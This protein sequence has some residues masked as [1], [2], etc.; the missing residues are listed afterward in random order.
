MALPRVYLDVSAD[1]S[2]LG[3]IVIEVGVPFLE[4][5]EAVTKPVVPAGVML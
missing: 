3:R 4:K 1:G 5:R 2:N